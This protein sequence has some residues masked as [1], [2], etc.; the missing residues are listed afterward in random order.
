MKKTLFG[1]GVAVAFILGIVLRAPGTAPGGSEEVATI[2]KAIAAERLEW[3]A[4]VTSLT[5]L[6][7]AERRLRLGG[8]LS[9]MPVAA[10]PGERLTERGGLPTALD[11]RNNGG[12]WITPVRDQGSCGSCWAFA[13]T[14]LLE[15]MV[16]IKK[17]VAGDTDL[18]EQM[19]VSCSGAGDCARG[20]Y[21]YKAAQYIKTT[22]I[23]SESCFPYAA[24]DSSC[25]P[26]ANW[27][28]KVVRISSWAWVAGN[29]RAIETALQNGPVTT[30]MA[31]YSDLYHYTAGVYQ[32]TAGA[33]Y[34]G[35]HFVL[36]VGYNE[37]QRYWICKNS[38]GKNWGE[39]GFFRIKFGAASIG[40]QVLRMFD[41]IVNNHPPVLQF[42]AD[43]GGDEGQAIAFAVSG[44]DSD[45]DALFYSADSLPE[46]ATLDGESGA[47]AWTPSFTQAGTYSIRFRVSD[48]IAEDTQDVKITVTNLKRMQ[49]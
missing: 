13:T 33:T 48:G 30:W 11:W 7:P 40:G 34:E 15:A 22:G 42:I 17:R 8:R 2:Q 28:S 26:C 5:A 21:E 39:S 36:I 35:G 3:R 38:W 24:R 18:S 23:P 20:G 16:K 31:V 46:G 6:S 19:L 1:V 43:C 32:P 37:T 44:T 47:F 10:R 4:G 29:S 49:W 25:S 45:D 9:E 12:N 41:P 27:A 14:A